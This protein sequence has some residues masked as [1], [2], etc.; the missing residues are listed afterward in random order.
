MAPS[1][2][3]RAAARRP[4]ESNG[5]GSSC[6]TPESKPT[7]FTSTGIRSLDES[8]NPV[9]TARFP[10]DCRTAKTPDSVTASETNVAMNRYTP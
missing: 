10:S 4:E 6:R 5:V 9:S 2:R 7:G 1:T 3:L 8:A